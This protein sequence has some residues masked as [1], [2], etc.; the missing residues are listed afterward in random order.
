[1]D[2][3]N[4]ELDNLKDKKMRTINYGEFIDKKNEVT[5]LKRKQIEEYRMTETK[6]RELFKLKDKNKTLGDLSMRTNT[7][8]PG[9]FLTENQYK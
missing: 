6:N 4:K 5:A 9:I 7:N 8:K 1:M 2:R 3:L